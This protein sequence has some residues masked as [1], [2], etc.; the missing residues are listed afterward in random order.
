[1]K[2]FQFTRI[3]GTIVTNSAFLRKG[4]FSQNSLF[5][6]A[7]ASVVAGDQ[8]QDIDE[9]SANKF[10]ESSREKTVM[11]FTLCFHIVIYFQCVKHNKKKGHPLKR[12][13]FD[14]IFSN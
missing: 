3:A 11:S 12:N 6:S 14:E 10:D 7:F 2:R 9:N 13:S 8:T 4:F 1:M 5:Q